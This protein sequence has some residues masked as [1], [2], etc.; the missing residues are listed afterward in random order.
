MRPK[1]LAAFLAAWGTG[2]QA[3]FIAEGFSWM[4]QAGATG[5]FSV[6]VAGALVSP[7]SFGY[8]AAALVLCL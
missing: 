5:Q 7:E 6:L 4:L 8:I 3:A 2:L 1:R